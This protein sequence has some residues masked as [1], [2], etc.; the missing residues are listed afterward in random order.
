MTNN[1]QLTGRCR[2]RPHKLVFGS[3]IRLILQVETHWPDGPLDSNGMPE[4]LAGVG[5]RDARVE[6]NLTM[7]LEPPK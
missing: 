2:V 4:Y 7:T 3:Q 6:D 1:E 5:W